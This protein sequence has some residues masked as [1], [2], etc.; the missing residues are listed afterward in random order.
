MTSGFL[1]STLLVTG[2]L[3]GLIQE[4]WMLAILIV[5]LLCCDLY[6]TRKE[7]RIAAAQAKRDAEWRR[8]NM[9]PR[10]DVLP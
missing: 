10:M 2:F 7:K 3:I 6:M 9:P 1:A 8:K 5:F 4:F